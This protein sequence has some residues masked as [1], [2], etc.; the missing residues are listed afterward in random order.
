MAQLEPGISDMGIPSAAR[1]GRSQHMADCFTAIGDTRT[2]ETKR[3]DGLCYFCSKRF[4]TS[5][6]VSPH[7]MGYPQIGLPGTPLS[8]S[9]LV[10]PYSKLGLLNG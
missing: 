3:F 6:A 1:N 2:D 7:R 9:S 8:F 10:I 5:S 4:T